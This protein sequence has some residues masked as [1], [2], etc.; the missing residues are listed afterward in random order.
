MFRY[1]SAVEN[2]KSRAREFSLY[3]WAIP[4]GVSLVLGVVASGAVGGGKSPQR[5]HV[6]VW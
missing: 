4:F 6:K 1:E 3:F 2:G 5:L